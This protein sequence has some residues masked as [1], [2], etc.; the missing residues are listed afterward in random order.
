MKTV[1]EG[2]DSVR[3]DL[4]MELLAV[5][6]VLT[7]D[8]NH[9]LVIERLIGRKTLERGF[10]L[11]I[12][13]KDERVPLSPFLFN[14]RTTDHP[15]RPGPV[16][17]DVV[18]LAGECLSYVCLREHL[19]QC[20]LMA[21]MPDAGNPYAAELAKHYCESIEL[22][23]I[24]KGEK[25]CISSVKG[26]LRDKDRRVLLVDP[27]VNGA[28]PMRD[29]IDVLRGERREVS[30]AVAVIYRGNDSHRK[31]HHEWGCTLHWLFT[32]LGLFNLYAHSKKI[33]ASLR[34]KIEVHLLRE[35]LQQAA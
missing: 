31:L 1:S 29:S 15:T 28:S 3:R 18:T 26:T 25:C 4:A 6:A 34:D 14:L 7:A 33:R 24:Q 21:G 2:Y 9:P 19:K 16:T 17:K 30:G 27:V 13:D 32:P 5:G 22:C 10:R 23:K 20:D 35:H 12:H 11:P 8:S